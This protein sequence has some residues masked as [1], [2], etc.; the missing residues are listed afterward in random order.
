MTAGPDKVASIRKR[1]AEEIDSSF[2][3]HYSHIIGLKELVDLETARKYYKP[4]AGVKYLV[5]PRK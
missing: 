1:I 3:T 5:D 4:T 2:A